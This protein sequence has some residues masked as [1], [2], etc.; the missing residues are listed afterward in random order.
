MCAGNSALNTDRPAVY[1]GRS[2]KITKLLS[3]LSRCCHKANKQ[4]DVRHS[5]SFPRGES[6]VRDLARGGRSLLQTNTENECDKIRLA[7]YHLKSKTKGSKGFRAAK[8]ACE[9]LISTSWSLRQFPQHKATER[10]TF[11]EFPSRRVGLILT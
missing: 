1:N 5:A 7:C 4:S 9:T 6:H 11:I 8:Q 10:I 2:F 3:F